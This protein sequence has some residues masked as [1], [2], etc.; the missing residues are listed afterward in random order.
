MTCHYAIKVTIYNCRI[1]VAGRSL[2]RAIRTAELAGEGISARALEPAAFRGVQLV[3]ET[4]AE[5]VQ[6]KAQVHALVAPWLS[7]GALLTTNTSGLS[8]TGLV[9]SLPRPETFA[10]LH[11][12]YPAD[13][14]PVVEIIAGKATASETVD[15]LRELA[16][17]M[18]KAPIVVH[19][20]VPGFV[21]N[22][23][24]HALLR[25]A[26]WLV[27]QEVADIATI[28]AAVS[29][30]LAPRWLAAGPFATVD[31]GG[32]ET[33]YRVASEIF[34]YLASD[35]EVAVALKEHSEAGT[36]FYEWDSD[37]RSD[38]AELRSHAIK[39][40]RDIATARPQIASATR[41]AESTDEQTSP[42]L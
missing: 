19:R 8:I 30:G 15:A 21:W 42:R 17:R 36:T 40:S 16:T 22:R 3:V 6:V 34:P 1:S 35:P 37:A 18:G 20:D 39:R 24:Q 29:D 28:D 27:D 23:L 41:A 12:L 14:T 4:V 9:R 25:E 33:W 2:D 38:V 11:F 10:G 7:D 5:D 26:L 13:I 32:I 31:L